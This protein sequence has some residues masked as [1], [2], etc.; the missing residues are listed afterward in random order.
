MRADFVGASAQSDCSHCPGLHACPHTGIAPVVS[1]GPA[2]CPHPTYPHSVS[3][4]TWG[5]GQEL[6]VLCPHTPPSWHL[7]LHL[8][9]YGS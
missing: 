3:L 8:P 6:C 1:L 5:C 9:C 7:V 4:G 2:G